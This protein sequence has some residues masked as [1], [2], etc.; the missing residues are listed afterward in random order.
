MNKLLLLLFGVLMFT[1]SFSQT[2]F[3]RDTEN[4]FI[5]SITSSAISNEVEPKGLMDSFTLGI[6]WWDFLGEPLEFYS[7]KWEASG[8]IILGTGKILNR[9]DL[10][11]YP[12][13]LK[14]F[15]NIQPSKISVVISGNKDN[16]VDSDFTYKLSDWQILYSKAGVQS[17]NLSP[18]SPETWNDF[19]QW[20]WGLTNSQEHNIPKSEFKNLS[21]TQKNELLGKLKTKFDNCKTIYLKAHIDKLEWPK[22]EIESIYDTFLSYE[23]GEEKP[24][25]FEELKA[26]EKTIAKETTY[27]KDDFWGDITPKKNPELEMFKNESGNYGVKTKG[28]NKVI[29][30]PDDYRHIEEIELDTAKKIDNQY[31]FVRLRLSFREYR[32]NEYQIVA[33]NG[34]KSTEIFWRHMVHL[35][36]Y[37]VLTNN[38]WIKRNPK[39]VEYEIE[40][41]KDMA[42]DRNNSWVGDSEIRIY[43]E[44]L[45]LIETYY[46]TYD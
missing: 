17:K 1:R 19:W 18:G 9:K 20:N 22:Y 46:R 31:F 8:S 16:R 15:D 13:L 10:E 23:K 11:K 44:N 39:V 26:A 5:G 27:T 2:E 37:S 12:D 35:E 6:Q 42:M 21:S 24:S 7:F 38:G 3:N 40:I 14:R 45:N 36:E 28:E 30:S 43:D 32:M 25:P 33:R 29:L 4:R 41:D 34:N